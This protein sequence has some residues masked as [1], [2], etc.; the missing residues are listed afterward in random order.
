MRC[1]RSPAAAESLFFTEEAKNYCRLCMEES[2]TPPKLHISTA[3]RASHTNHACREVVLDSLAL[4]AMRGYPI[5]DIYLVWADVLY[6]EQTFRRIPQLVSPR[7][8]VSQRSEVLSKLLMMLKDLGVIDIS[9][10]AQAPD[11]FDNATQQLHHRRRVAFERLEYIG[12]NSWGNHLSNRMMIL[13]PD[14]QW[15]YS[16]NAYAFNCFR[17][18]CEMNV[19]LEFMFDT[20]RVSELLPCG[21]REKLG[22]GKIKADV[23]EAVIGELHVTLWGLEPQLY[24]SA[25][26]V[27]VNGV[28]EARLSAVVEHCLTEIYDLIMLSYVQE[29]SGSALPLAKEV[30]ASRIW[31]TVYPPVRRTKDRAGAARKGRSSATTVI[32][33][34]ELRQLPPLPSLFAAPVPRPNVMPHPLRQLRA[35]GEIP[36]ETVCAHTQSDVFAR[37]IKSY[38]GLGLLDDNLSSTIDARRL[39]DVRFSLLRRQ[40]VPSLPVEVEDAEEAA[41]ATTEK[42]VEAA[43]TEGSDYIG[44]GGSSSSS[45]SSGGVIVAEQVLNLE[46]VYFRDAYFDIFPAPLSAT[47]NPD[48][49]DADGERSRRVVVASPS[50]GKSWKGGIGY[51]VQLRMAATVVYPPLHDTPTH[52]PVGAASKGD[53]VCTFASSVYVPAGT[54]PPSAGVVTDKNLHFGEFAFLPGGTEVA[55]NAQE[56]EE[57]SSNG[58][59]TGEGTDVVEEPIEATAAADNDHTT[60][61]VG[62]AQGDQAGGG[63]HDLRRRT[64]AKWRCENPYFP[65]RAALA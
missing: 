29:L 13:F 9:L 50:S 34:G 51:D 15:A 43:E 30:A 41:V 6:G 38:E 54:K 22:A 32:G 27:E 17:D 44:G 57:E 3:Y 26:F 11:T 36:E 59:T 16:Q 35:V 1:L 28:G 19:T 65:C 4:L 18:A 49:D 48:N 58:P 23:L 10:A 31:N 42:G 20:L 39:R 52:A 60:G 47:A 40:L 25:C 2:Q 21:V 62:S 56:T 45:R 55:N 46:E 37:F 14:K 12:D 5:D 7:W 61:A 53:R 64:Q 24:D 63:V 33:V 8:S